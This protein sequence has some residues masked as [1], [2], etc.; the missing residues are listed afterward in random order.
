[1]P[2]RAYGSIH[3]TESTLWPVVRY[4]GSAQRHGHRVAQ[5]GEHLGIGVLTI[6]VLAHFQSYLERSLA[7]IYVTQIVA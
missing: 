4:V 5:L 1:M 3:H 6:F 7:V 2:V